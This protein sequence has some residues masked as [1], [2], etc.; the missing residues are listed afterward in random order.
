[1]VIL[2]IWVP[3]SRQTHIWGHLYIQVSRVPKLTPSLWR[4]AAS[5]APAMNSMSKECSLLSET[6]IL[7]RRNA[8][9]WRHAK[10]PEQACEVRTLG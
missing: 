10:R 5:L 4:S 8:Y 9:F 7:C 1:M 6:R 2:Y 3:L